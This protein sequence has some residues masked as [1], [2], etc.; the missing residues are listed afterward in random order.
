[1]RLYDEDTETLS[2]YILNAI[3]KEELYGGDSLPF[4]RAKRKMLRL[5]E[6]ME[7]VRPM[8]EVYEDIAA[9]LGRDTVEWLERHGG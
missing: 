6:D 8:W 4:K 1:M 9:M 5:L 7:Q 2:D 3:D